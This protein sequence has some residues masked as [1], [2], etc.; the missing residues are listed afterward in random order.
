MHQLVFPRAALLILLAGAPMV[1]AAEPLAG[2]VP[3]PASRSAATEP[4]VGPAARSIAG[5]R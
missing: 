3:P 2:T 1:A 5:R 4:T